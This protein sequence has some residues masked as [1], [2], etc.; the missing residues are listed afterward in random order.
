M[1]KLTVAILLVL[2]LTMSLFLGSCA[3]PEVKTT[4][5]LTIVA[6][7]E[8]VFDKDVTVKTAADNTNGPSVL[9]VLHYVMDN[10]DLDM[11]LSSAGNTLEKA[12]I[13]YACDYEEVTYYWAFDIN[14]K[15][16]DAGKADTNY[17]KEGD[18]VTYNFMALVLVGEN[19]TE[20]EPYDNETRVFEDD[21]PGAGDAEE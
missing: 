9:D 8:T 12:G 19:T 13:Y 14:D 20:E 1:K 7:T 4:V 11:A 10:E 17:L 16:P 18:T 5:H 21:L 6:G 3:E 2:S 15:A